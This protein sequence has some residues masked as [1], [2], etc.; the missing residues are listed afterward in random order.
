MTLPKLTE[1]AQ[2]IRHDTL[3]PQVKELVL[4]A[5]GI[6]AQALP[7]QFIHL[8]VADATYHPLLRRPF[9]IAGANAEIGTIRIIYRIV[10]QG[11]RY[12]AGLAVGD[13]VDC[14][15]PLGNGFDL[16]AERPVLVGGG[17][18]LAPLLFLAGT[19]CPKPMTLVMGG[20]GEEELFWQDLFKDVCRNVHVTTNDGSLGTQ[21]VVTDILPGLLA[22]NQFDRLYTCGPHPM[23]KAVAEVAAK[24]KLSCQISLEEYMACGIGGCLSCT[25]S[26]PDGKRRKVC[27][28]GPVFWNGEVTL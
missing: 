2:V 24:A 27:T 11:T 26:A 20:R 7:G 3:G 9:S 13:H 25:C 19:L 5:P 18:G 4:Q 1:L 16:Q 8:R 22:S 6:A 14:L 12:L 23:L 10:G 21:G 15:G 28:D 17:M